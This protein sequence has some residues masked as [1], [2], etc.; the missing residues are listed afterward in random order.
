MR[1]FRL[2]RL[3]GAL[4]I[5]LAASAALVEAALWAAGAPL[6]YRLMA[7]DGWAVDDLETRYRLRPG[8]RREFDMDYEANALGLRGPLPDRPR[9]LALGDSCTFGV[10][11]EEREAY[12]FLLAPG[13]RAIDAAVPG[14]SAF[15]ARRWLE[16]ARSDEWRPELV[17]LY[18]GWNDSARAA[19]TERAFHAARRWSARSRAA[20]A[21]VRLEQSIWRRDGAWAWSG[22]VARVPLG[23]FEADLAAMAED[24]RA[25]GAVPVL[26]TPASPPQWRG[27]RRADLERYAAAARGV[28]RRRGYALV[29]FAAE[30][31]ALPQAEAAELFV[32]PPA[33]LSARGHRLLAERLRPW[34]ERRGP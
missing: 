31:A 4:S 33:H 2:L 7:D 24:A 19:L 15:N 30:V 27:A 9:V 23:D 8:R 21:V 20:A 11:V 13:G 29:D 26:I 34:L 14:W 10:D 25:F 18:F 1:A 16:T 12:P 22:L 32:D 3:V 6:G 28:A 5:G 17:T